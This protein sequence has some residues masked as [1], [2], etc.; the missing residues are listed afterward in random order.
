MPA[1]IHEKLEEKLNRNL[2]IYDARTQNYVTF[3][4]LSKLA[5]Y[6]VKD[7]RARLIDMKIIDETSKAQK[8]TNWALQ[9]ELAKKFWYNAPEKSRGITKASII[10]FST[11]LVPMIQKVHEV[12]DCS[13]TTYLQ[14]LEVVT[15][16]FEKFMNN[17]ITHYYTKTVQDF[18]DLSK[19]VLVKKTVTELL[20]YYQELSASGF[21]LPT[22]LDEVKEDSKILTYA[23]YQ[24]TITHKLADL[25]ENWN[26]ITYNKE[27]AKSVYFTEKE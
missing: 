21:S 3:D 1:T 14:G 15:P 10:L 6:N 17:L 12:T 2:T 26:A 16:K 4:E 24:A 13:A 20:D 9:N 25:P 7:L 23:L 18:I 8:A 5:N 19:R 22:N 27:L 11:S